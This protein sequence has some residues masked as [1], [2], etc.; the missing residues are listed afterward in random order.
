MGY[1]PSVE[2]IRLEATLVYPSI[3]EA[4][5]AYTWMFRNLTAEEKTRLRKYVR[6]ISTAQ[7]D[8]TVTVHRPNVPTW[9]FI[10][11][12]PKQQS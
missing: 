5:T 7:K 4:L 12:K 6:S 3:D 11:W 9:A 8:G 2:Y 1:L 10:S